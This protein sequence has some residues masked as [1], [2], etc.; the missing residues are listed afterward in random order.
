MSKRT[1]H[2]GNL[3]KKVSSLTSELADLLSFATAHRTTLFIAAGLSVLATAATLAQ[4]LVVGRVLEAIQ[5]DHFVL[6]PAGMLSALFVVGAVLSG[7]TGYLLG[8]AGEGVVLSLRNSLVG[9]LLRMPVEDHERLRPGDLISRIST[10]TTLL[11]TALVSSLTNAVSGILMVVGAIALMAYVDFVLLAVALTCV[12]VATGVVLGVSGRIRLASEEAQRSVGS[13]SA[14]LGRCLGAIRTVKLSRA[15]AREQEAISKESHDAYRAG[16]RVARLDAI[17]E[18]AISV[19]MQV[20]FVLVLGVG[21]WR[22][23]LEAISLGELVSF[24]LYLF[25]LVGPLSGL[26]ASVADLQR[27]L[28]A[29]SR[30]REVL[31]SS[32]EPY[33]P[34]I[35]SDHSTDRQNQPDLPELPSLTFA[36]VNFA[37]ESDNPIL[38]EVSI[39][40]PRR[41]LTAL[42]G[43]SGA[44]KSTLFT[45]AERLREP[46]GGTIKLDG[47]NLKELPLEEVRRRIGLVEQ[48]APVFWGSLR[49]NLLYSAPDATEE[50]LEETLDLANLR[51]LVDK[52]PHRLDTMVGERGV[53]LSGGERQ[54]VAIARTLLAKPDV[55]LLDEVTSQLDADNELA[56]RE[57]IREVSKTKTVLAIAHRLST[58]ADAARIF[59]LEGGSVSDWG[60]H[61]ELLHQSLLYRRLTEGQLISDGSKAGRG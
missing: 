57:T 56:L 30:L 32:V 54:R 36:S 22:L 11:R 31:D 14:T 19:T 2:K 25:Y 7:L 8:R 23:A 42:V 26:F 4:P 21:G 60:T 40:V 9:R 44:G 3:A 45:L 55:L 37:Y 28:G 46:Q 47:V 50:E 52:L 33:E 49:E 20:A 35:P 12:V 29:M 16:V 51:P 39:S 17:V 38:H 10:D 53:T 27:G 15:E 43:P 61:E 24:L 5:E 48:D 41:N 6:V 34:S 18:P 59:V 13:L 58:V 1:Q